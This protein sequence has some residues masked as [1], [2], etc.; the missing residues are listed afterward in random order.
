MDLGKVKGSVTLIKM[1]SLKFS[2]NKNKKITLNLNIK[3]HMPKYQTKECFIIIN[4]IYCQEKKLKQKYREAFSE[5]Q[6][7]VLNLDLE[8]HCSIN[9]APHLPYKQGI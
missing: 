9:L 1:H 5:K 7:K 2:S 4:D 8:R 3:L 6:Q